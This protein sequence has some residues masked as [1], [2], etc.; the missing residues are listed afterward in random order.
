MGDVI[1]QALRKTAELDDVNAV[2]PLCW[3]IVAD[4][5]DRPTV[6]AVNPRGSNL[7]ISASFSLIL[8]FHRLLHRFLIRLRASL[9]ESSA[10]N[11]RRRNPRITKALASRLT[12]ALG[13]ALSG[14]FLGV[15][16]SSQLRT[17]IAIYVFTR[18]LEFAY[19]AAEE[20]GIWGRNGKPDWVGSW[21]VVPIAYGQLLHAFV[22]DRDCFPESFG[23]FILKRSPEYIQQRPAGL[24]VSNKWPGT[25]DI[26][27][28]LAEISK[29][30]WP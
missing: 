17:T 27:D 20:K 24:S 28:G 9:L 19:N 8:L 25:F 10:E 4:L 1:A 3:R 15:C 12:P 16:P 2:V 18:S 30:N 23:G 6:K 26:V 21:M 14:L 22:F 29:L 11:F 13:A 5:Q 7:R